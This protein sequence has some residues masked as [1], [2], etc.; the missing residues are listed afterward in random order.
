MRF[1][2]NQEFFVS[3]CFPFASYY[4]VYL[5]CF[6]WDTFPCDSPASVSCAIGPYYTSYSFVSFADSHQCMY[7][8]RHIDVLRLIGSYHLFRHPLFF[9]LHY[10]PAALPLDSI[11]SNRCIQ[12]ITCT[13]RVT[14]SSTNSSRP[15]ICIFMPSWPRT[16]IRTLHPGIKPIRSSKCS[17]AVSSSETW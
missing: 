14:A 5:L 1:H 9:R 4:S 13:P 7:S 8:G 16:T 11:V 3:I 2:Q 10:T 12:A 6:R 15:P 17:S